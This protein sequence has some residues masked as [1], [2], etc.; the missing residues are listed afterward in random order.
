MVSTKELSPRVS[1]PTLAFLRYLIGIAV[2]A[3][4]FAMAP[5][6]RFAARDA[7]VIA[8]LG[9]F[10]F[11]LLMLLLNYALAT[12]SASTCALVFSTMPLFTL[13]FGLVLRREDLRASKLLGIVIAVSGVAY[14]LS[15][16]TSQAAA[17]HGGILGPLALLGATLTGALT[18][19]LYAPYLRRYPALPTCVLAMAAAVFFLL[20]TC[21]FSAQP[22]LPQLTVVEWG[23]ALLIGLSSG[24]GFF[25]W[26]WALA[27]LDASRVVAFQVLGPI[28]AAIIELITAVRP[29]SSELLISLALVCGGLV[30]SS[31][32]SK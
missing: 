29:P 6:T 28:T 32:R 10:Q 8:L 31:S 18:S 30:I 27:R 16:T 4:P 21:V 1:P 7:G 9:V 25:C 14:L 17:Q 12:L 15:S 23:H 13:C 19:L 24:F 5:A 26:L 2:L 11:G 20:A 3:L 22:L